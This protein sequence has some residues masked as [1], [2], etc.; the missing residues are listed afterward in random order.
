MQSELIKPKKRVV[1]FIDGTNLFHSMWQLY[2]THVLDMQEFAAKLCCVNRDLKQIRYYYSPF[3]RQVD[4]RTYIAQQKL[5]EMIKKEGNVDLIEGKYVRKPIVL[6]RETM[7]KINPCLTSK[8]DLYTYVEK[9]VDVKMAVDAITLAYENVYDA[10]ILVTG[11]SDFVPV[12]A[13]LKELKKDMQVAMFIN[14]GRT[15]YDLKKHCKS[16]IPLDYIIPSIL[17]KQKGQ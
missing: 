2:R 3:I 12:I 7:K 6:K 8:D 1:V 17:K 10:A 9:G 11:D 15:S 16:I 14:K 5:I 13:K 4:Q